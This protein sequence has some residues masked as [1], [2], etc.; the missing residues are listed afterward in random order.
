M[1]I[2]QLSH[3][4]RGRKH[5]S[6]N[7]NSVGEFPPSTHPPNTYTHT[8]CRGQK[9]HRG[10]FMHT[11]QCTAA[12]TRRLEGRVEMGELTGPGGLT[13]ILQQPQPLSLSSNSEP[14]SCYAF[15]KGTPCAP[16]TNR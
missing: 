7:L 2:L 1:I 8:A 5:L 9:P 6:V 3:S 16:R 15:P 12:W 11:A 4:W 13:A 14:G 10:K